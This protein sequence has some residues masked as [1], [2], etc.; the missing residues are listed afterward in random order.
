MDQR[1]HAALLARLRVAGLA[2][3]ELAPGRIGP[4]LEPALA[5]ALAVSRPTRDRLVIFDPPSA[6]LLRPLITADELRP[7]CAGATGHWI[8]AV[9]APAAPTL[10]ER[11]PA[12][13]AHLAALPEPEGAAEG[14]APW[15]ALAPA[16]AAPPAAPRIILGGGFFP[17]AWDESGALVG[18]PATVIA[19]AEP[20]WLALLGSSVG[21]WLLGALGA[22]AFPVPDAPGPSQANLAGLALAAAG[23]AARRD[24]LERAVLRRLVADFGPP[25]AQPGHRL[26]RWWQLSFTELHA[27]VRDELRNDIPERFRPTWEEIHAD[28]RATHESATARLAELQ[29]AV[30]AQVAA[31]F[32]LAADERELVERGWL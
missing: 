26:R 2:L 18:G 20:Y 32:G 5:A 22:A 9:P 17:C 28:Q 30:D 13:A 21:T 3:G 1:S 7:W 8:V 24:E 11:H 31:L 16:A 14:A 29:S 25:G 23:L 6:P 19:R 4:A 15:W 10:A 12:V 27:A